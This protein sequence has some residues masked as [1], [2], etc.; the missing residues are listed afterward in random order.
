L[1][2]QERKPYLHH[3][4][5]ILERAG[6]TVHSN[7]EHAYIF[8]NIGG[9][10]NRAFDSSS[11]TSVLPLQKSDQDEDVISFC[12][13]IKQFDNPD[14]R[15]VVDKAIYILT[16]S[17]SNYNNFTKIWKSFFKSEPRLVYSFERKKDKRKYL[18]YEIDSRSPLATHDIQTLHKIFKDNNT[19]VNPRFEPVS[20]ADNPRME[21]FFHKREIVYNKNCPFFPKDW[22]FFQYA[23]LDK[24]KPYSLSYENDRFLFSSSGWIGL[25]QKNSVFKKGQTYY[26]LV[27]AKVFSESFV[28][29][30]K[31]FIFPEGEK[32]YMGNSFFDIVLSPGQHTFGFCFTPDE[33]D[34]VLNLI[35]K[36]GAISFD[37]IYI[38]NSGSISI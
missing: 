36:Q 28:S 33:R 19:L 22:S 34:Y 14:A 31:E 11:I 6:F 29:F 17:K 10:I 16:S 13:E 37:Y 38:V 7:L 20:F 26:A 24:S 12:E 30:T 5:E 32:Y 25:V 8:G 1:K 3:Y 23:W 4:N 2:S 9:K 35:L 27:S 15:L 21:S 18:V